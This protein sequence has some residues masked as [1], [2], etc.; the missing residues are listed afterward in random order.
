MGVGS[1]KG[2]GVGGDLAAGIRRSREDDAGKVFEVHLM[3]DS[4]A[5][6]NGGEVV[7]GGLAPLEER[8]ALAVAGELERGVE[9]VGVDRAELVDLDG[10]VD[11]Q[12]GGLQRVDLLRVAAEG[13]HGIP[14]GRE[15]DD[16]RHAGKVLHQHASGH[17][18]DLAGR[19]CLGIPACEEADVVG[20]DGDAVLVAEEIFKQNA[21]R[22]GKSRELER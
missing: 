5:G 6:R 3:A 18:G 4:H 22:E 19:L 9:V 10:V 14:H 12:L 16:G 7:E 17:V 2:V 11:D 13:A 21:Q 8:V 1:D 15:I 20:G